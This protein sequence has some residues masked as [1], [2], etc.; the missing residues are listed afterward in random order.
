MTSR[1][2][3]HAAKRPFNYL[4]WAVLATLLCSP[5]LGMLAVWW[6]ARA[7]AL[8]HLGDL[9]AARSKAARAR[10]WLLASLVVGMMTYALLWCAY[11]FY[12]PQLNAAF[13]MLHRIVQ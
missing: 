11:T 10:K 12:S 9:T 1:P 7:N 2:H 5:P 13:R 3:T 8:V 4:P 6:S